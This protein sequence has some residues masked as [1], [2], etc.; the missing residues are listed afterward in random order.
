MDGKTRH[1][2]RWH[3]DSTSPCFLLYPFCTDL[4]SSLSSKWTRCRVARLH[5]TTEGRGMLIRCRQ[6]RRHQIDGS[7]TARHH[8]RVSTIYLN[9]SHSDFFLSSCDGFYPCHN[10]RSGVLEKEELAFYKKDLL[11]KKKLILLYMI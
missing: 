10:W 3:R 11:E 4:F 2:Q 8:A 9:K 5:K 7:V 6:P 1:C